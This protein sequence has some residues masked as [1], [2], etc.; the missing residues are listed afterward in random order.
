MYNNN[1]GTLRLLAAFMVLWGHGFTLASGK[2]SV[3]DPLS[4]I[5]MSISPFKLALPGLG[6]ALFFILS[7]YL[8]T[9]SQIK[10]RG[11]HHYI[12]SRVFRIYPALIVAVLFC[13][14]VT[15]SIF[16]TLP[17]DVYL[18]HKGTWNFILHNSTLIQGIHFKLPGVF[19]ELPWK[20][21]VNGS[22][23]TLP[24]ELKMYIFVAVI[25]LLGI[26]QERKTF[27][28]LGII[29]V[30]VF[31]VNPDEFPL[32]DKPN[33]AYLGL[34]FLFGAFLKV[35]EEN[36]VNNFKIILF[37]LSLI[38]Y[39]FFGSKYYNFFSLMLFSVAVIYI[40]FYAKFSLPKLDKYGDFSYG[41]YLYAFPLQ[42]VSIYYLGSNTPSLNNIVALFGAMILAIFSWFIVEKPATQLKYKLI[43]IS[44][45]IKDK[46]VV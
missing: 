1:A 12:A 20:G 25:G 23:W 3:H 34:S 19:N 9:G 42:Q 26:F 32:L 15:G 44:L 45:K 43:A 21:G 40:S 14:L 29:F 6:V 27:N 11:L 17:L 8:I 46:Y 16:T 10:N 22:L 24:I 4:H 36:L 13:A 37:S 30:L 2:Q 28:A 31:L 18:T 33:H 41:L 39:W 7:G 38:S 35:N 5:L